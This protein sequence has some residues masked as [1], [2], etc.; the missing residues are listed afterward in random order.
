MHSYLAYASM[1]IATVI[2]SCNDCNIHTRKS[3]IRQIIVIIDQGVA[4]NR[5]ATEE[6]KEV[7]TFTI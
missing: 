2:F 5:R 7:L 3:I 4:S 1:K 6:P